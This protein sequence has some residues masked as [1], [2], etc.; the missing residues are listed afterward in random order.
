MR[1]EYELKHGRPNPYATR[2]GARGRGELLAWWAK[3][4]RNVRVLP[5]DVAREFLD[6][7][8]TV[9]ALRLVMKLRAVRPKRR[10]R[11]G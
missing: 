6:S 10:R 1:N 8:T 3:S 11:A 2:L 4:T 5:D 9:E 7:E